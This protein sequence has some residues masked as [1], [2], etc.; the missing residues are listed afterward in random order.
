LIEEIDA[1]CHFRNGW[2]CPKCDRLTE[3]KEVRGQQVCLECGFAL[4][5]PISERERD[6]KYRINYLTKKIQKVKSS[7]QL[8]IEVLEKRL[9]QAQ[10]ELSSISMEASK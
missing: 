9:A 3:H 2:L 10:E 7:S 8:Q 1:E 4:G 6:L 5:K